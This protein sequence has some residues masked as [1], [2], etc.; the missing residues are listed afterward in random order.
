MVYILKRKSLVVVDI[1]YYRPDHRNILQEFL[2][3]TDDIVPDIPRV[4]KFL[5]Y[6]K[7]NVDAVIKEIVVSESHTH[8][9]RSS[10][11]YKVLTKN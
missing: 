2:W 3:S 1:L 11:F 7:N 10:I 5:N 6:W 4:H 8:T 9:Y